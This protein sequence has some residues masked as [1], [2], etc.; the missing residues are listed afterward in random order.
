VESSFPETAGPVLTFSGASDA[1]V[2]KIIEQGSFALSL[3]Q[4]AV[5]VARGRKFKV[6]VNVTHAA[7]FTSNV[8]ISGS[9]ASTPGVKFKP[10]ERV[11]VSGQSVK[12]TLKVTAGASV[13]TH[14]VVFTGRGPGGEQQ[15]TTLTL[16]IQ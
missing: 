16:T 15:S 10:K 11:S 9:V 6:T 2:A 14:Q 12:F 1:F 8:T 7:G 3:G 13:G 4:E 5:T